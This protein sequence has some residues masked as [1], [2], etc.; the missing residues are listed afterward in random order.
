MAFIRATSTQKG[1]V[2]QMKVGS[3]T[4][5]TPDVVREN[6]EFIDEDFSEITGIVAH[7]HAL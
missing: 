3:S 7:Y 6:A 4:G 2:N 5:M 1:T